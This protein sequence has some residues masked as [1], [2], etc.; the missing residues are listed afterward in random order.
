MTVLLV[1]YDLN[2]PGQSYAPLIKYIKSHSWARLSESTYA[3]RTDDSPVSVRD[4]IRQIVD[5]NDN[6]Y[7]INLKRPFSGWGPKDVNEWLE[8]NLPY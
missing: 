8:N 2:N 4:R 1:T 7:V 3:I 5:A 6:V